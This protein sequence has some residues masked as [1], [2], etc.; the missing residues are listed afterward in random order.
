VAEWQFILILTMKSQTCIL[1]KIYQ[2]DKTLKVCY[3]LGE[4]L[5]DLHTIRCEE[6]GSIICKES[7]EIGEIEIKCY[8]CN[9]FNYLNYTSKIIESIF[10]A[11][12]AD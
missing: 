1:Y 11:A 7:V 4:Q 10:T 3:S 8:R 2:L 12:M 6:C 9:H 5:A